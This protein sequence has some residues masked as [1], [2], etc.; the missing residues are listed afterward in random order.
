MKINLLALLVFSYLSG[1]CQTRP[2]VVNMM[3]GQV[4][5]GTLADTSDGMIRLNVMGRKKPKLYELE[6]YRVFSIQKAGQAES[7]LYRRDTA[8][9]NFLTEKEMK[10]FFLGERDARR[11][12]NPIGT[13]IAAGLLTF[14]ICLADTYEK[15]S[16]HNT[17]M[18]GFFNAEP[19]IIS[20]VSP[21]I[22]T[23]LALIPAVQIRIDKV[24]DKNLLNEQSYLDGFEKI[25]RS[26]K[27]FGA[28]KFS[29]MGCLVGLASYY[30]GKK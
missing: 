24:S 8:I 4:F 14:G 3:N 26:K 15:D 6:S 28:L 20:F 19:G 1:F 27:V 9:G 2:D 29:V 23:T 16:L 7:I 10:Y 5:E 11:K 18:K 25:G 17:F 30:I 13:K 12:Y 21:L 22:A